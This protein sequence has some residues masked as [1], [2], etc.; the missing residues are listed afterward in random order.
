VI[1]NRLNAARSALTVRGGPFASETFKDDSG[2]AFSAW[3][4]GGWPES[5]KPLYGLSLGMKSGG[6]EAEVSDEANKG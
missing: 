1:L 5:E 2:R 4:L 3:P 6:V